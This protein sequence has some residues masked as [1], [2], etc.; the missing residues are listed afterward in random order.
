M[1]GRIS[2]PISA[3]ATMSA[4]GP[5]GHGDDDRGGDDRHR[6]EHVAHHL[7]IGAPHVEAPLL[8]I[9]E[10]EQRDGVHPEADQANASISPEAISGGSDSRCHAS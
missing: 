10:E 6:T 2:S 5:A 3:E 1:R 8:R 7:E 4:T 9:A